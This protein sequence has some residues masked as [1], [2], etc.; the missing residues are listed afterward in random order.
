MVK[1]RPAAVLLRDLELRT[2]ALE[3]LA[4]RGY[5][6]SAVDR[7]GALV[8]VRA[9]NLA[10][11]EF[12]PEGVE[13]SSLLAAHQARLLGLSHPILAAV[14]PHEARACGAALAAGAT[15]L[16]PTPFDHAALAAHLTAAERWAEECTRFARMLEQLPSRIMLFDGG[17]RLVFVNRGQPIGPVDE[18]L[19]GASIAELPPE[20]RDAVESAAGRARDSGA[21]SDQEV[22]A[23]GVWFLLR[24]VPLAPGEAGAGFALV[25]MDITEHRRAETR[26]RASNA[27]ATAMLDA[28]PDMMFRLSAD[29]VYLDVHAERPDMLAAPRDQILGRRVHDVFGAESGAQ[30][31]A[32]I[33]RALATGEVQRLEFTLAMPGGMRQ[34]EARIVASG[35]DEVVAIVRD[36]T[37]SKLLQARLALADRLAA[38]GTLSAGVAHEIN[39]PLTYILIG[40][41]SVLKEIRR[42]GPDEPLGAR[43]D[44]L[45]E[46]L[47]GAMEGARRVRRIVSDLR[48]F[49]R[50]D[51][52][53][54]RLI[55]P[56]AVLDSAA[57]MVDSAIRYRARLLRDYHE[58]PQIL[59][60][61]DRL[62]QV[63]VNLL[64]NAA[65]AVGEGE[66]SR[67]FIR[68]ATR[69][70]PEGR[71][72]IEVTDSG[73]GIPVAD[74]GQIFDPFFTT[75]PVGEGTG[76]GLWVCH[77]IVTGHGGSISVDSRRGEGT[78][79]RV[80]LPAGMQTVE[81]DGDDDDVLVSLPSGSI[82]IID[83]DEQVAHSLAI[84][85]EG[86]ELTVLT[87]G[88]EAV[89]RLKAG[90]RFDWIFCDLMMPD[91]SGM[92]VYEQA[93]QAG[94]GLESRFV[95][96]TG[97][98]FTPR[99][100]D[101][102]ARVPNPCLSK[103]FHPRQVVAA[104]RVASPADK[105]H[106]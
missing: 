69:T 72:V 33:A 87:S 22:Q 3:V 83:D 8:A 88:H 49:G 61:H 48:T 30:A 45:V 10:V 99:A 44:V 98:I 106:R 11:L 32:V 85:F 53:Q 42:R 92:D 7:D 40:I 94:L 57:S 97:G 68:I 104:L 26:L 41:E 52:E 70:D 50:A 71:V 1:S 77:S 67:N 91:L 13:H 75:K 96:M 84:L 101:F 51:E 93:H 20:L 63:F 14:D 35:T 19:T 23:S 55:D 66:T 28:M 80:V 17:G 60:N 76:L 21:P 31:E 38:L 73:E 65:Q 24:V 95:F 59:G 81:S 64:L 78:T 37:E 9:G 62:V 82:L 2:I 29:G 100:R 18:L 15:M 86:S 74:L 46:R 5:R 6:V 79:F 47:Q 89:R 90:A 58:V 25:A 105:R 36:V 34:H 103:P 27:K 39:N 43:L 4:D 102:V 56:R 16:V 54:E 12:G